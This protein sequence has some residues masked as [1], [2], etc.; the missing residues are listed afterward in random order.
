MESDLFSRDSIIL[1]CCDKCNFDLNRDPARIRNEKTKY[2]K[3]KIRWIDRKY[4]HLP[5]IEFMLFI[6][7]F[8]FFFVLRLVFCQFP[9]LFSQWYALSYNIIC[10]CMASDMI[11]VAHS[12]YKASAIIFV[13][14]SRYLPYIHLSN[15]IGFNQWASE[16]EP[17][18]QNLYIAIIQMVCSNRFFIR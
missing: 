12:S 7:L 11:M 5:I 3:T 17:S 15:E 9:V 6:P 2:P 8:L 4:S 10:V 1:M 18:E 16:Y 13:P 14:L